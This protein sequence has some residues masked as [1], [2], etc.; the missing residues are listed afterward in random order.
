M[1]EEEKAAWVSLTA[2][3]LRLPRDTC[4]E[5]ILIDEYLKIKF[6]LLKNTV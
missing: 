4:I 1:N 5:E 6:S 3:N 2:N